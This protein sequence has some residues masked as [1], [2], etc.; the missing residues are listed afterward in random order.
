M[1]VHGKACGQAVE[2][3]CD[4]HECYASR[5]AQALEWLLCSTLDQH[6]AVRRSIIYWLVLAL[7]NTG[8]LIDASPYV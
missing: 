4:D 5:A 6:G 3:D 8:V 2:W 1:H 7:F